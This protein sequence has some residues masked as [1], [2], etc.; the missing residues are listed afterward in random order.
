MD[1]ENYCWRDTESLAKDYL[2]FYLVTKFGRV[3]G[4]TNFLRCLRSAKTTD[5]IGLRTIENLRRAS[6]VCNA[7]NQCFF[8]PWQSMMNVSPLAL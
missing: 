4:F 2:M 1:S 6:K 5:L 3:P 8:C 7:I